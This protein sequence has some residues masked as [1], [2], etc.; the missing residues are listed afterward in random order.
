MDTATS[1]IIIL[2]C[3]NPFLHAR[4]GNHKKKMAVV[5]YLFPIG[6]IIIYHTV[7][8]ALLDA[9]KAE[10]PLDGVFLCCLWAFPCRLCRFP[11]ASSHSSKDMQVR[12]IGFRL[13]GVCCCACEREWLFGC[14][15]SVIH[16]SVSWDGLWPQVTPQR[17][18]GYR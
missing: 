14:V 5:L 16:I 8:T 12:L 17:I 6:L 9:N 11:P 2:I 15:S 3:Q 10:R 18:S 7:F 4:Q 1:V 13:F